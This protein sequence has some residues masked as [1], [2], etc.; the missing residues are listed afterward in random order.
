MRRAR[1]R[2]GLATAQALVHALPVADGA[3]SVTCFLDVLEHLDDPGPA[4]RD[5][6]RALRPGGLL[7]VTVPAHRWQR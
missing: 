4:L 3:A 6:R 7:V 5:A 2:H 1:N